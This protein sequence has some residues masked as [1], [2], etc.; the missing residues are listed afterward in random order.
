[1][2]IGNAKHISINGTSKQN[3]DKFIL[4]LVKVSTLPQL[5]NSTIAVN[6]NQVQ[7]SQ[8]ARKVVVEPLPRQ[9]PH[10]QNYTTVSIFFFFFFLVAVIATVGGYRAIQ[11]LAG[12]GRA[13]SGESSSSGVADP[14]RNPLW[15]ASPRARVSNR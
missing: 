5:S 6:H 11:E 9:P 12:T 8:S 4:G 14:P 13:R 15:S 10:H 7:A 3:L 2:A 1:M